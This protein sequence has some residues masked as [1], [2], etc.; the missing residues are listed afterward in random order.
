MS[1][2][3]RAVAEREPAP[4]PI[5]SECVHARFLRTDAE[6]PT[7]PGYPDDSPYVPYDPYVHPPGAANLSARGHPQQTVSPSHGSRS[8]YTDILTNG[9]KCQS[10]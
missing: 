2:P 7:Y 8:T 3:L 1:D 5:K 4:H 6:P 9:F 10:T